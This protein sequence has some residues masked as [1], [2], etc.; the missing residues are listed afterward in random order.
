MQM[1]LLKK[2]KQQQQLAMGMGAQADDANDHDAADESADE[3]GEAGHGMSSSSSSVSSSSSFHPTSG[4]VSGG[5]GVG[6]GAGFG[7][8]LGTGAGAGAVQGSSQSVD[9]RDSMGGAKPPHPFGS[10]APVNQTQRVQKQK[11]KQKPTQSSS[12]KGEYAWAVD[13]AN[14]RTQ[15]ASSLSSPFSVPSSSLSSFSTSFP[16]H[17]FGGLASYV[18]GEELTWCGM[19]LQQ[20][21]SEPRF[22]RAAHQARQAVMA[23]EITP[24]QTLM[25]KIWEAQQQIKIHYARKLLRLVLSGWPLD[26]SLRSFATTKLLLPTI[27]VALALDA[28]TEPHGLTSDLSVCGSDFRRSLVHCLRKD[29]SRA[30]QTATEISMQQHH[31][32]DDADANSVTATS[33]YLRTAI[34]TGVQDTL[35]SVH[36]AAMKSKQRHKVGLNVT[37]VDGSVSGSVADTVKESIPTSSHTSTINQRKTLIHEF[38]FQPQP[39]Q[40]VKSKETAAG[41]GTEVDAVSDGECDCDRCDLIRVESVEPHTK[42]LVIML[43]ATQLRE[44][45]SGSGS[46]HGSGRARARVSY[47]CRVYDSSRV[48]RHRVLLHSSSESA[49][50]ARV[51]IHDQAAF[52]QAQRVKMQTKDEEEAEAEAEQQSVSHSIHVKVSVTRRSLTNLTIFGNLYTALTLVDILVCDSLDARTLHQLLLTLLS[53]LSALQ[54]RRAAQSCCS[55]VCKALSSWRKVRHELSAAERESMHEAIEQLERAYDRARMQAFQQWNTST[56]SINMQMLMEVLLT[57]RTAVQE[58]SEEERTQR[59]IERAN[60]STQS[61]TGADGDADAAGHLQPLSASVVSCYRENREG[62][63]RALLIQPTR[64]TM[65]NESDLLSIK[66]MNSAAAGA[67]GGFNSFGYSAT[68]VQQRFDLCDNYVAPIAL[69]AGVA[70]RWRFEVEIKESNP[71]CVLAIGFITRAYRFPERQALQQDPFG[72]SWLLAAPGVYVHKKPGRAGSSSFYD[73]DPQRTPTAVCTFATG[74]VIGVWLDMERRTVCYTFNG[75]LDR[76][77][78]FTELPDCLYPALSIGNVEVGINLG[79]RPFKYTTITNIQAND[80]N[81]SAQSQKVQ[82]QISVSSPP[83]V[84]GTDATGSS[85]RSSSSS[86]PS[87][88]GP[89]ECFDPR[90]FFPVVHPSIPSCIDLDVLEHADAFLRGLADRSLPLPKGLMER[91]A[92]AEVV[93]LQQPKSL[94]FEIDGSDATVATVN[95]PGAGFGARMGGNMNHILA[96]DESAV[97]FRSQAKNVHI[98]FKLADALTQVDDSSSDDESEDALSSSSPAPPSFILQSLLMRVPQR[99]A[100]TSFSST[101]AQSTPPTILVFLS[102]TKPADFEQFAWT[103]DMTSAQFKRFL[104]RK[105]ATMPTQTTPTANS[106]GSSLPGDAASMDGCMEST[107]SS[108]D[109]LHFLPHEPVAYV[110]GDAGQTSVSYRFD[111]GMIR[112]ARYVTLKFGGFQ[113]SFYSLT[114]QHIK[115]SGIL[116][117]SPIATVYGTDK[118]EGKLNEIRRMLIEGHRMMTHRQDAQNTDT[119]A[120]ASTLG[121][122]VSVSAAASSSLSLGWS[123]TMDEQLVSLLQVVSHR[124]SVT[125]A[126]L[127]CVGSLTPTSAELSR[128]PALSHVPLQA[129][130]S[131]AVLIKHLNRIAAPLLPYC[132]SSHTATRRPLRMTD[133]DGRDNDNNDAQQQQHHEGDNTMKGSS[134]SSSSSRTHGDDDD[135]AAGSSSASACPNKNQKKGHDAERD[136]SLAETVRYLRR[137]Y[138]FET[139]KQIFDQLLTA[140]AANAQSSGVRP[141]GSSSFGSSVSAY[142]A[143]RLQVNRIRAARLREEG[144]AAAARASLFHQLWA[145]MRNVNTDTFK[146]LRPDQQFWNVTF[147]GEGSID[148]GGPARESV[149]ELCSDLMSSAT[150]LMIP[151]PNASN[152]I[153]L[154]RSSFVCAPNACS[155][156]HL[157][158]FE[159]IGTLMGISLRTRHPLPLDLPSSLWKS[160]LNEQLDVS[161]L[162]SIDKLCVQA[163]N[164]I[165]AMD[166]ATFDA[167]CQELKWTTQLSDQTE[168]ELM[169]GGS[170][171]NV[172]YQQR[173]K[174]IKLS[175]DR[176]LKESEKQYAAIRKGLHAVID[177]DYLSLFSPSDLELL[178]V[179]DP[180]IDVESLRRHTVYNKLSASDDVVVWLFK[181]LHSFTSEERQLFLRYVWGRNRLPTTESDWTSSFTINRMHGASDET[182]P[183]AH[184]CFFSIDLPSYSSYAILRRK[185][186]YA[187]QNCQAIDIDFSP[188]TG[189]FNAWAD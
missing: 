95:M 44:K 63:N 25:D 178:I 132:H 9:G 11:Q 109:H 180:S 76:A 104:A 51:V 30:R 120:S 126:Q 28:Q 177:A 183:V 56:T 162:E 116:A 175:I 55:L 91:A 153:G 22:Q 122:G 143:P 84:I 15:S 148:V 12:A 168:V 181:A 161:D 149:T 179:G 182:L 45:T 94:K 53:T 173:Q 32:D 82:T 166:E 33:S 39:T 100:F 118:L 47:L 144:T 99:P 121:P 130:R 114:L 119:L 151:A 18:N 97:T 59:L 41:A 69:K 37:R 107:E 92:G 50:R 27:H 83:S 164:E 187:I 145:Q 88:I 42:G 35:E 86:I 87:S 38:S 79:Q 123:L 61:D 20:I 160:L 102:D 1:M 54:D 40:Q 81:K 146:L 2:K 108:P 113:S 16:S 131:R 5:L 189:G 139:K 142:V 117:A 155:T 106:T 125:S 74:T 140:D 136:A 137:C 185:L 110:S 8:G 62:G 167:A 21:Q 96:D 77:D 57:S 17:A 29:R 127:D 112:P 174:F 10:S 49:G 115:M 70:S 129:L 72:Q 19:S 60:H 73:N 24:T 141:F 98:T 111:A 159:F 80:T 165:A 26:V 186:L 147:A 176:R 90:L 4:V 48:E 64:R 14:S 6:L 34:L 172:T 133:K 36:D 170:D 78:V 128:F 105:R 71:G 66:H 52:I 46:V 7:A 3:K 101:G 89:S 138:F 58:D 188:S 157:S 184:T 103:D 68:S 43:D 135:D 163:L 171:R 152:N 31:D 150:D 169:E 154:N 93:A 156:M 134:S 75:K 13:D 85:L 158:Q 23:M 124:L 65:L 67:G